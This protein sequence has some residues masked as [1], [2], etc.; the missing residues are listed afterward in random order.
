MPRYAPQSLPVGGSRPPQQDMNMGDTEEPI[1]PEYGQPAIL[2]GRHIRRE[3]GMQGVQRYVVSMREH[4]TDSEYEDLCHAMGVPT[5]LQL[6][7]QS[8]A[9]VQPQ[10][11]PHQD[12]SFQGQQQA[13]NPNNMQMMQTL[14][15]MMN[16]MGGAQGGNTGG[17]MGGMGGMNTNGMNPLLLAQMLQNGM[18]SGNGGGMNGMNPLLLAQML[19]SMQPR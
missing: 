12:P 13:A 8:R 16:G 10:P 3:R 7:A 14:M 2:L 11:A 5:D 4:L 1:S 6:P 17:G 15:Q 18:G 19:S 9:P